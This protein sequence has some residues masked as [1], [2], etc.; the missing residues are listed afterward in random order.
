MSVD[1]ADAPKVNPVGFTSQITAAFRA[2]ELEHSTQP[3]I[4]DPLARHLGASAWQLA[5]RDR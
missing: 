3:I 1:G 5:F 4:I 2:V